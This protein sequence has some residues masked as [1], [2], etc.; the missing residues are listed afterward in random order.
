MAPIA[1]KRPAAAAAGSP[2]R[3]KAATEKAMVKRCKVLS[4]AV[5]G[6]DA[7]PENART[8]V[9]NMLV[10]AFTTFK[11]DRHPYQASVVGM[12]N[13]VIQ[14]MQSNLQKAVSD[15][16]EKLSAAEAEK[17]SLEAAAE[18]TLSASS[19]AKKAVEEKKATLAES[20][21]A[22]KNAK[23]T[24]HDA[25]SKAT[26][27][28]ESAASAVAKHEKVDTFVKDGFSHVK[29]GTLEKG[30]VKKCISDMKHI[31]K[32]FN[33]DEHMFT[34]LASTLAKEMSTWGSLITL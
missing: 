14:E 26:V 3:K 24:L 25:E 30:A 8:M 31:A 34:S 9:S 32:E 2:A 28:N 5:E 19:A 16:E 4:K 7:L 12:V 21:T 6:A 20:R 22:S 18:S 15:S 1:M 17:S 33:M 27:A 10:G 11:D 23:A 29:E 13:E